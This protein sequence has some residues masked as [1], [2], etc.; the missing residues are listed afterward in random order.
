MTVTVFGIVRHHSTFRTFN[1]FVV[2][3]TPARPTSFPAWGLKACY[4]NDGRLFLWDP[5]AR[6]WSAGLCPD[7]S[8]IAL[9]FECDQKPPALFLPAA[10]MSAASFFRLPRRAVVSVPASFVVRRLTPIVF[11]TTAVP[12]WPPAPLVL[13]PA[14]ATVSCHPAARRIYIVRS[15]ALPLASSPNILTLVPRPPAWHPHSAWRCTRSGLVPRR[16]RSDLHEPWD[17]DVDRDLRKG[18]SG[19]RAN[20]QNKQKTFNAH[21]KSFE[22]MK[23]ETGCD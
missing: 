13:G 4:L 8:S 18:R 9:P 2:G 1:P 6:C 14:P 12:L 10:R 3:S 23:V 7:T 22:A 21:K 16:R 20:S 11:V 19:H 5:Q 17:V 15:R